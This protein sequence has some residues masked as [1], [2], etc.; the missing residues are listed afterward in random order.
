[1][2]PFDR[3]GKR[4]VQSGAMIAWERSKSSTSQSDARLEFPAILQRNALFDQ[5][6]MA[7]AEDTKN[8]TA[9]KSA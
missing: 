9:M 6:L 3:E 8:A 7:N 2:A 5:A 4:F 1:M